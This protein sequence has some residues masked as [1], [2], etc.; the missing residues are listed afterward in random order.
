MDYVTVRG[1]SRETAAALDRVE[2]GES[3]EVRRGSRA[4]AR[5]IPVVAPVERK[6]RWKAHFRWLAALRSER[7]AGRAEDPVDVLLTERRL[8]SERLG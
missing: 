3:L 5:L 4:V 6:R 2:R 8:R 1:L 7:V